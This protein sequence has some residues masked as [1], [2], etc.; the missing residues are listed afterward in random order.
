[1]SGNLNVRTNGCDSM[2]KLDELYK[3]FRIVSWTDS[4]KVSEFTTKFN[5]YKLYFINVIKYL[6]LLK[7]NGENSRKDEIDKHYKKALELADLY[8]ITMRDKINVITDKMI[9]KSFKMGNSIRSTINPNY[10]DNLIK[11]CPNVPGQGGKKKSVKQK[12]KTVK[13]KK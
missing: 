4:S 7:T 10:N 12:P 6:E 11:F 2:M 13:P 3:A 9:N 8:H 5:S 1:M